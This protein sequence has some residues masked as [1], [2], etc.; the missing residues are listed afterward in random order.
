[1]YLATWLQLRGKSGKSLQISDRRQ[2]NG[3]LD[4]SAFQEQSAM[5]YAAS[6]WGRNDAISDL[7]KI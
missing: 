4:K 7:G 1:V 5:G 6:G 3:R 2:K